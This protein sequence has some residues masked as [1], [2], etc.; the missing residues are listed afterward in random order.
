MFISCLFHHEDF[1]PVR[2]WRY[3]ITVGRW[4]VLS[5]YLLHKYFSPNDH[6]IY[7]QSFASLEKYKI[8]A[9]GKR[10]IILTTESV[11]LAWLACLIGE[12]S[13]GENYPALVVEGAEVRRKL[14][15]SPPPT[16][17]S[18]PSPAPTA[19]YPPPPPHL[20]PHQ[21]IWFFQQS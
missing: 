11:S 17:A 20:P 14:Q 7:P 5:C 4:Q 13:W 21:T 6:Q 10:S 12:S 3:C 18:L 16:T 9:S 15:V 2:I 1:F 19:S 8:K